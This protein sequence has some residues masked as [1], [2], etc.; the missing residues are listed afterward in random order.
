MNSQRL[1]NFLEKGDGQYF[2]FNMYPR[3][4]NHIFTNLK[5]KILKMA[6][7]H[8]QVNLFSKR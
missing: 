1:L 4:L 3:I 5:V 2:M 6:F 8:T 7:N